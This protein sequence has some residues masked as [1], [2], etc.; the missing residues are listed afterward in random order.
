ME[1]NNQQLVIPKDSQLPI[2]EDYFALRKAGL[3]YIEELTGLKQQQTYDTISQAEYESKY[4][5]IQVIPT[6]CVHTIKKRG[7]ASGAR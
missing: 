5:H 4:S 1:E 2:A 7:R 6:M 3:S